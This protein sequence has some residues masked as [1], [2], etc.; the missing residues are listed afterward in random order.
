MY[1]RV[2]FNYSLHTSNTPDKQDSSSKLQHA[3]RHAWPMRTK[4]KQGSR[5]RYQIR[6]NSGQNAIK[7]TNMAF[8]NDERGQSVM[9]NRLLY[10]PKPE[11]Y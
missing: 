2:K 11:T 6:R 3:Q 7:N 1:Y 5:S 8:Y 10:I 4:R 9:K